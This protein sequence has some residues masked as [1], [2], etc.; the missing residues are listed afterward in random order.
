M[1]GN[2]ALHKPTR[3]RIGAILS[4]LVVAGCETIPE[5]I[6]EPIPERHW[7]HE[8]ASQQQFYQDNS[9]CMAMSGNVSAPQYSTDTPNRYLNAMN[10]GMNDGA[11]A[12]AAAMQTDI[13]YQCMMG[14]GYYMEET[15]S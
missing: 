1:L 12:N 14:R 15:P 11:A 9:N 4:L 10:A 2:Y 6:P 3:G 5:P 8:S 7:A 13:Y